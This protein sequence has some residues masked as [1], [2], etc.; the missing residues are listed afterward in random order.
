MKSKFISLIMVAICGSFLYAQV[1]DSLYKKEIDTVVIKQLK[2]TS[3]KASYRIDNRRFVKNANFSDGITR[4]EYVTAASNS[5]TLFYKGKKIE[6]FLLNGVKST[7]D[8]ISNIPIKSISG[9]EILYNYIDPSTGEGMLAMNVKY[10]EKM[11]V[12]GYLDV[13]NGIGQE[14]FNE[15]AGVF[16]K[17]QKTFINFSHN[18]LWNSNYGRIFQSYLNSITNYNLDRN[19]HQSFNL[20]SVT[21]HLDDKQS[22]SFKFFYSGI[23]EDNKSDNNVINNG[24]NMD[25]YNSNFLYDKKFG[26]YSF[27]LNSDF[28]INKNDYSNSLN[29]NSMQTFRELAIS[30]VLNKKIA[31]GNLGLAFV[32][33]HRNFEA[34]NTIANVINKREKY[35]EVYNII[36]S[37]NLNILKGLSLSSS[38]RY[39]IYRDNFSENKYFLPYLRAVKTF[40]NLEIEAMY[41]RQVY[42]PN[43]YSLSGGIYQEN[44]G[45]IVY[46][47]P[48]L[49]PQKTDF[50]SVS[51]SPEIKKGSLSL[52][53]IYEKNKDQ[54]NTF[55]YIENN[56]L[57]DRIVNINSE[58]KGLDF[59]FSYPLFEN[60]SINGY[61]RLM[62][63]K[64]TF[65][66]FEM[67]DKYHIAGLSVNGRF[68]ENYNLSIDSDYRNKN[69]QANYF[70]KIKP[71]I[72]IS[73]SR[74]I[75]KE[76]YARI[77]LRNILD[78]DYK[79]EFLI[80]DQNHNLLKNNS[81]SP[82]RMLLLSLS[83]NFG[84]NFR[85]DSKNLMN[86]NNDILPK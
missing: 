60:F 39:Q 68:F 81:Y 72:S 50:L 77:T 46:T 43:I 16:L 29:S 22:V 63:I 71:D 64:S 32:Y 4:V 52:G 35:Q 24:M 13:S 70:V 49:K 34:E 55:S 23:N 67:R 74:S 10:R 76:V 47:N 27:K 25:S 84:K 11:G 83:Y 8:E 54:V 62:F 58:E 61:Y 57:V 65:Q 33:T 40:N 38:F 31:K 51:V 30:P 45:S 73:V 85:S 42:N 44:N 69:Y 15:G 3:E 1:K 19:L 14:F 79:R 56:Q 80:P 17:K 9:I 37:S 18:N 5:K 7:M 66:N 41:R 12:N 48:Y 36:L 2:N 78:N 28:I 59:S 21:Q 86:I 82:S 26:K 53:V 20:F 6:L 75:A